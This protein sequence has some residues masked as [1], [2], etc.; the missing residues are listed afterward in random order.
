MFEIQQYFLTSSVLWFSFF[1]VI[2]CLLSVFSCFTIHLTFIG[3]FICILA[4]LK[5][6]SPSPQLVKKILGDLSNEAQNKLTGEI[7]AHRAA[8][9]DA[10]ENSVEA[11]QKA[12]ANG[13]KWIEFDI[14]FTK[15]KVAVV[16]HDDTVDRVTDGR[17]LITDLT[18]SELSALNIFNPAG[19][20]TA[21]IPKVEK[22]VGECLRHNIKMIIDLK[23]YQETE[24]TVDL[25]MSLYQQFPTLKENSIVTSFFPNLTYQLRNRDSNIVT[26]ISTRPKFLSCATWE[27][28]KKSMRPRFSG[29]NQ[30]MA[31]LFD[32]VFEFLLEKVIWW[33]LG[34]S[35]IL[36]HRNVITHEY[37]DR[38]NTRGL[39]VMAWTVNCPVEKKFY[40]EAH[41][42]PVLSDTLKN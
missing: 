38:W 21:K 26:A 3:L 1:A 10:P 6:P 40:S 4:Y 16:F 11:V 41:N 13:V 17:G 7:V 42:V 34:L 29:A 31:I 30:V 36:V 14:S 35:C 2:S 33:V 15:D 24:K 25:L 8:C 37:V 28:T 39:T 9:L 18:F 32:F 22:F 20:L 5:L 27:G 19:G 12:A 23:T